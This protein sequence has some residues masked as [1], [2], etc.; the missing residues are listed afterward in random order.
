[1]SGSDAVSDAAVTESILLL[2]EK[3]G[4]GKSIC[5]SE[6]ARALEDNNWRELMGQVRRVAC[7][8]TQEGRIVIMQRRVVVDPT[9]V[10]GPIRIRL[11][12]RSEVS[13]KGAPE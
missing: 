2:A 6:V 7:Q 9:R 1:M 12:E 4:P 13:L 8:L 3:R 5:P 10:R 11:A